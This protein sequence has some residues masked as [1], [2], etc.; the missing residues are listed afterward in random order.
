MYLPKNECPVPFDQ[1][2]LNEYLSL[3]QSCLFNWSRYA[4]SKY[5]SIILL[6]FCFLF[7]FIGIFLI[8]SVPKFFSIL[9]ILLLDMLYIDIILCLIFIRLYLGWSYIMNRLLSS[10]IFYEESGWYDGQIWIKKA[11]HLIKDRLVGLYQVLPII[12]KVKYSFIYSGFHFIFH[13]MIYF[14]L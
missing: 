12:K 1:Q 11:D 6:I 2:P 4:I 8:Y 13:V 5:L 3:S 7:F 10:S 9:K 14:F